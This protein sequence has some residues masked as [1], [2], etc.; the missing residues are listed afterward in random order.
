MGTA[1]TFDLIVEVST[2]AGDATTIL[3]QVTDWLH[4][5]DRT[6]TTY[7]ELSF[8]SRFSRGELSLAECPPEMEHIVEMCDRYHGLTDGWFDAWAGPDHRFDPSGIVK[9]WAAQ[10]ASELLAQA[11][12]I[13]HCVNAGGDVAVRGRG[14]SSASPQWGVGITHPMIADAL[15]A[16]I[17][18]QDE[19]VATSGTSQ[20][21]HHVWR[22]DGTPSTQLASATVVSRDLV[23]ADAFATAALARGADAIEWLYDLGVDAY[24]VDA[25]GDE[26]ST[27]GF[28]DRR[29]WPPHSEIR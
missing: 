4:W 20:R 1:F 6:F 21:G 9:G 2:P 22:R 23:W 29:V 27:P 24:V 17:N 25:G 5:A 19:C 7:D 13:R 3:R 26:W 10:R 11:G 12:F 8:I 16:V 15:C 28:L 14:P 18:V